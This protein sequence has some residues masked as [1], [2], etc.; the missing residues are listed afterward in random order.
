M[1]RKLKP[2]DDSPICHPAYFKR[3]DPVWMPGPVP[4]RYWEDRDHPRKYLFW[5]AN[6]LGFRVMA[7]FYKLDLSRVWHR[8]RGA[9]LVR[10]WG[11]LRAESRPR[12]LPGVPIGSLG[13]FPWYQMA[14]GTRRSIG[15]RIWTGWAWNWDFDGRAIGFRLESMISSRGTERRS[16]DATRRFWILCRKY[17]PEIDW[18]VI[19][20]HRRIALDDVLAWADA[21]FAR[22]GKWPTQTSGIIPE[23][24]FTW[25]A[26]NTCLRSGLHGLPGASSL[27]KVLEEFRCVPPRR[28]P[29]QFFE[30]QILGWAD[31]YYK[32]HGKW[33]TP[34]SGLVGVRPRT[35]G[36]LKMRCARAFA[37]SQPVV[38]WRSLLPS[39]EERR[40]VLKHGPINS[41]GGNG[42]EARRT[43]R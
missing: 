22:H 40:T 30:E 9:G 35:G 26:I 4:P 34:R 13:C 42:A 37:V 3:I 19:D 39:G 36:A 27:P 21:H 17:L 16:S 6:R 2:V 15:G 5:L 38:R 20:R 32:T 41:R 31:A 43:N 12:L 24:R 23:S 14:S 28:R 33:P 10:Y 1:A 18:E 7:D 11:N 29:P 8:H 25:G